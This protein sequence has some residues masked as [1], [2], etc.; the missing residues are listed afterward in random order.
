MAK[1]QIRRRLVAILAADIA[2][3][4][5]LME[6]DTDGTS[7]ALGLEPLDRLFYRAL[8][9]WLGP[10]SVGERVCRC[11][12]WLDGRGSLAVVDFAFLGA[13]ASAL[14]RKVMG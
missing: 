3:Y 4:T 12:A 10:G 7:P 8:W 13:P 9:F 1:R 5:R 14:Q 11:S 6:E 2:G